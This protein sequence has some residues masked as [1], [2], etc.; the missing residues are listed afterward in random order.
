MQI[1][2]RNLRIS[3][4]F[5]EPT[6]AA[7]EGHIPCNKGYKRSAVPITLVNLGQIAPEVAAVFLIQGCA[8]RFKED[9]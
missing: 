9:F 6:Q 7:G 2:F 3:Q 4:R 5:F 1:L 8:M